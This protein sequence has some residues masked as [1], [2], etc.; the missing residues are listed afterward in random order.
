MFSHK[1]SLG[2]HKEIPIGAL[3]SVSKYNGI[4]HFLGSGGGEGENQNMD[5]YAGP[6]PLNFGGRSI[7]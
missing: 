4:K 2:G 1:S 7:S 3:N 5:Q 6:S